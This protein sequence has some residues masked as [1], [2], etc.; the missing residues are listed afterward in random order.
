M[1]IAKNLSYDGNDGNLFNDVD[2]SLDSAAQKR[3]AIVG[4]NG[5]GKTTLLKLLKGELEPRSG[6]VSCIREVI[7][8]LPQDI[9]FSDPSMV[10]GKYLE[11]KLEEEWMAYKIDMAIE[12]VGL[13][14]E[15]LRSELGKLSG[16]QKVRIALAE[17]LLLE[18]TILMMDEPTN[19]L[20]V[21]SVVW[22]KR[23]VREFAGTVVFVS[24]D[25]DFINAVSNQIL[26][27]TG[28]KKIEVYGMNYDEFLVERYNR[29]QKKLQLF[30]FSQ[31]EYNELELWLRENANHPKYKF[32][33]T[34]AQK[35]KALERLEKG[36][37]PEPVA[38]PRIHMKDLED[39][40]EGNVLIAKI[41]KKAFGDR[42]ILNGLD[43]RVASGER[44]L[45]SGRNGSG[46]TTLMNVIAGR[47]TDFVGSV[48][49]RH[50]EKVGYLR[51]FCDLD[52]EN[53][54]I[55]EFGNKTSVEYTMRR[56][57]LAN[58]LFPAEFMDSAIKKLSFGQQRRLELSILL[59]N[60]PDLLL[61]DEP[62]NHLDIFL[63][64]DLENFLVDQSVAM[65][66]ISHDR[67]FV[68]KLKI[69]RTIDLK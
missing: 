11:S 50:P 63:R 37:P 3:V 69:G 46:K 17:I 24:H 45:V 2:V 64:E 5:C 49:L 39:A 4:R 58:F 42:E 59:T 10:A 48:K 52:L 68:E 66:V 33:S 38:D 29:Y 56:A 14:P 54:V 23:F 25:R 19:H 67:Y 55:E 30:E 62:T 9:V 21:Q 1:L 41:E 28:D 26:E 20:D 32:T 22:L 61:L 40:E 18:P 8:F 7:G 47:D 53:T 27:I 31:R 65:I 36:V 44:I 16:G 6:S 34:V 15:I 35:K 57:I 12:Q 60:K 13:T 43:F 51:Q